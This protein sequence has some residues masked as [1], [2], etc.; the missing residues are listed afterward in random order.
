M[1]SRVDYDVIVI[2][3]GI[4]GL[5]AG[6]YLAKSGVRVLI[7]EKHLKVGGYC[8]SFTRKKFSFDVGVH[9]L[10]SLRKG[11][12]VFS[13]VQDHKLDD[14]LKI[15]K[16]KTPNLVLTDDFSLELPTDLSELT[17]NIQELFP[18]ERSQIKD[19]LIYLKKDL[20]PFAIKKLLNFN[21]KELMDEYICS[22]RLKNIFTVLLGN[23]GLSANLSS[24]LSAKLLFSEYILDGGYYPKGGMQ[25]F[26]DALLI[27]FKDYGGD[28]ILNSSADKIFIKNDS[29]CAVG[30]E[31]FGVVKTKS[32]IS[33][34]DLTHTYMELIGAN[35]LSATIL[36]SLDELVPSVSA[37]VL[38]VGLN[39]KIKSN[40]N[41]YSTVWYVKNIDDI[42]SIYERTFQGDF[43]DN[44]EY[45]IFSFPSSHDENLAPLDKDSL[46]VIVGAPFKDKNFWK[47][48]KSVYCDNTTQL[49]NQVLPESKNNAEV[50]EAATPHTLRR[51]TNN[52]CGAMYGWAATPQNYKLIRK[53]FR[54]G[55]A[56]LFFSG[57][58]G[59]NGMTQ[60]G[61]PSVVYSGRKA[62]EEVISHLQHN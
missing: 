49:I 5:V 62:S 40:L 35:N 6:C 13:L 19:F 25:S 10:G 60:G 3:A 15:I 2:G 33:S 24:A 45:A 29:V 20:N 47:H 53:V 43:L 9:S 32:I 30:G 38:Y 57:H 36:K 7:I 48:N 46:T 26:S 4:G 58:W 12:N 1:K 50:I 31:K 34:C 22:E 21:F 55:I 27:K 18:S 37:F 28:I 39:T 56:G 44:N 41:S 17:A 14:Y 16:I 51:Y 59:N 52:R 23:I 8:S 61:V 54:T 42:N 11:G